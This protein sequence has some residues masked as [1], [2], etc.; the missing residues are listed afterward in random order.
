MEQKIVKLIKDKLNNASDIKAHNFISFNKTNTTLMYIE[1]ICNVEIMNQQIVYPLM[2]FNNE[3]NENSVIYAK[4]KVIAI[5]DSI[6]CDDIN[7]ITQYLLKG[8]C[9]LIF[10]QI[11][12][13]LLLNVQNF[14]SRAIAEPPTSAVLKGPREGFTESLQTN[15]MLLR[16]RLINPD[17]SIDELF[18]GKYSN[19]RICVCY[20]KGIAKKE[21]VE[22]IKKKISEI[23]I[24]GV[25]DSYYIQSF[26]EKK[27]YSLFK[28]VGSTEKPDIAVAKMLEGRIVIAVNGS[29][30]V[31]TLPFIFLEDIQSSNDYYFS[32]R[33]RVR[34]L[35]Y[36][37]IFGVIIA[38]FLPGIYVAIQN[39]HYKVIPLN[40]LTTI[41]NSTQGIPFT[42]LVE[43]LFITLLFEILYEASLRMPR[44]IGLGLS[45][46]GALILGETAV[47]AGLVSP[48]A[49]MIVALTG[50]ILY[51]VP[52]QEAQMSM[53]RLVFIIVG[54]VLGLYGIVVCA[55]MIL[56][57]L[58]SLE[59][60]GVSYLAPFA[61]Y[62]QNDLQDGLSK[63]ELKQMK[64]RPES[65][66]HENDT[67]IGK[68]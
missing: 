61:P 35:R 15:L 9:A 46:V 25:I 16:K 40:F 60:F 50:V 57:H 6:I 30:V 20:V 12:S 27:S 17:F 19:T 62:I 1:E 47:S 4:D 2:K 38:I 53:L 34:F 63:V 68:I 33:L 29:P 51:T 44:Y 37:R 54:G 14:Q 21:L 32:R 31:L 36:L 56:I 49:V 11:K 65:I 55:V 23:S 43:I 24:D 66:P 67:R 42:P 45:V 52:D 39:Y 28:Q 64:K 5:S 8:Y 13:V 41:L 58:S 18:V 48:P 10:N 3:N 7:E 26:L 22:Q 59:S